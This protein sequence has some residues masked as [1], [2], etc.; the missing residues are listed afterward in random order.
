MIYFPTTGKYLVIWLDVPQNND[1][2]WE[3]TDERTVDH[4]TGRKDS[5]GY[6]VHI[7]LG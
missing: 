5:T 1:R 6:L 4:H 3:Q 7:I 2:I